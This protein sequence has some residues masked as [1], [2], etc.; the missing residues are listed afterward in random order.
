[1]ASTSGSLR[2]D[3]DSGSTFPGVRLTQIQDEVIDTA[4]SQGRIEPASFAR[5][6]LHDLNEVHAAI[7]DL[8]NRGL[9]VASADDAYCLT[10]QGETI[11]RAQEEA[12]RAAVISRTRSWQRR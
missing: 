5:V 4:H 9:M 11:H 10:D 12:H 1:M 6:L 7:S 3:A 8:V 2:A